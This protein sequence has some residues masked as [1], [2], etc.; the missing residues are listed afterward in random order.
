MNKRLYPNDWPQHLTDDATV[1]PILAEAPTG[2]HTLD[3]K[4]MES[5]AFE[6]FC[7]WLL[8]KDFNLIG[9]QLVGGSGQAQGGID[10]FAHDKLRPEQ[11]V[12]FECKCWEKLNSTELKAAIARFM[13]GPW[14]EAGT[15]YVLIVAQENL[16]NRAKV[17]EQE[18]AKLRD[19]G[20]ECECWTAVHLTEKVQRFPDIIAKFF[21]PAAAQTFGNVWMQKVG[22]IERLHKALADER[23]EVRDIAYQ[24]LKQT[25]TPR[26]EIEKIHHVGNNWQIDLP[27]VHLD[28]LLPDKHTY[29]GSASIEIKKAD[30]A[31]LLVVLS[32][33]WF[34]NNLAGGQAAPLASSY[35]PFL[36]GKSNANKSGD[37]FVIDLENC[38]LSLP[39]EGLAELA[40][41]A[42]KFSEIFIAA[43]EQKE[44]DWGAEDFPFIGQD[45][46]YVAI[47]S[48]PAWLWQKIMDFAWAHDADAGDSEWHIFDKNR[49]YL[50]VLT[51]KPHADFELGYHGIF[52]LRKNLDE[53]S[54][55]DDVV[56][57]WQPPMVEDEC[58][59]RRW[60]FCGQALQWLAGKL[61]PAVG[62]WLAE[63]EARQKGLLGRAKRR[64]K[65]TLWWTENACMNDLRTP[66]LLKN[67][68]YR[69]LGLVDTVDELQ[70][71][72]HVKDKKIYLTTAQIKALYQALL[73]I[74]QGGYGYAGYIASNLGIKASSHQEIIA[75]LRGRISQD[76]LTVSNFSLDCVLRAFLAALNDDDTWLD[77]AWKQA[78]FTA[79]TPIMAFVDMCNLFKRH[80]KWL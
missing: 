45:G 20:I 63:N 69:Q 10:L 66:P 74:L 39:A 38:R 58:E 23:A 52:Y 61:V 31:G 8:R 40:Y 64:Q 75:A 5:V 42:D 14:C 68:R 53:L 24:Y 2:C 33:R 21:S 34:L 32:Q 73:V 78:I 28:A 71:Q 60:M 54:F 1:T 79:L 6:Q 7:W 4:R 3:F 41:V 12:V 50:K 27:W 44:K 16:G 25:A 47:C 76:E 35:R 29:P 37:A 70:S 17:W 13:N 48:M 36:A 18:S 15:R 51:T 11:L 30:T 57:A 72:M 65:F 56:I 9:C 80:T 49:Y 77:E 59:T 19:R 62:K 22:F 43:L 26:Q 67:Q 55:N 46:P